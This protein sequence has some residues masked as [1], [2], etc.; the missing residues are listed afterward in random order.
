[1]VSSRLFWLSSL[2]PSFPPRALSFSPPLLQ[3]DKEGLKRTYQPPRH[4][5]RILFLRR[6][7]S[8]RLDLRKHPGS[9]RSPLLLRLELQRRSLLRDLLERDRYQNEW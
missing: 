7:S 3:R 2:V 9:L 6:C 8:R 1:M 4:P 5:A